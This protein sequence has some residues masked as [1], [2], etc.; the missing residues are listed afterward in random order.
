[1]N[2]QIE[3]LVDATDLREQGRREERMVDRRVELDDLILLVA[4]GLDL[5]EAEH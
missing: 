2:L 1:M 3:T 4:V 5:H